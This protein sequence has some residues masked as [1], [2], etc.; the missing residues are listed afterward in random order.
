MSY[1]S[2]DDTFDLVRRAMLEPEEHL[3]AVNVGD[4]RCDAIARL[5]STNKVVLIHGVSPVDADKLMHGIATE[6]GLT[7]ELEIQAGFAGL[8]GHRN[9]IGKYF[10]S[11]NNR[12]DFAFIPPHSE[13]G[14]R[15]N[16]QL[17]SFYCFE[18]TTDGGETVLWGVGADDN[19]WT[20]MKEHKFKIRTNR[21]D[22]SRAEVAMLKMMYEIDVSTDFIH[23]DDQIV[24]LVDEPVEGVFRYGVLSPLSK[25]H[26]KILGESHFTCWDTVGSVDLD[27]AKDFSWAIHKAGL[28]RAPQGLTDW[29]NLDSTRTRK[30]WSSSNRLTSLFNRVIVRRLRRGELIVMNNITWAHSACG[31]TPGT[32]VRQMA[33]CFA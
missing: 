16:M 19:A 12:A 2:I 29:D 18:N 22:L 33:A 14:S 32:G 28:L 21:N 25:S 20:M 11:V 23:S 6:F 4:A 30:L 24:Q 31:W 17:A 9:N 5:I 27:I 26:S 13:G 3:V 1:S 7:S 15:M 8:H 10:M